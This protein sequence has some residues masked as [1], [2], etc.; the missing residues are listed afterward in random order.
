MP[1]RSS[2]ALVSTKGDSRLLNPENDQD[3]GLI[4]MAAQLA[5]I[6]CR[7]TEIETFQSLQK[8]LNVVT[9]GQRPDAVTLD[10]VQG[11][12][13][14][15]FTLRWRVSWWELFGDGS[16]SYDEKKDVFVDR[17]RNLCGILY[18]YFC[19]IRRK[20][21]SWMDQQ[22]VLGKGLMSYYVDDEPIFEDFPSEESI[23]GF[24]R[25]MEKGQTL[26]SES[27]MQHH[28][29]IPGHEAFQRA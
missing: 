19:I 15:L 13:Q 18:V 4:S 20:L 29:G 7:A 10:L 3:A 8:I 5:R 9:Q 12:G 14:I 16:K 1:S 2:Y 21:P 26:I 28:F 24:Q 23:E 27:G 22:D 6:N 17:V 25:W 11:L